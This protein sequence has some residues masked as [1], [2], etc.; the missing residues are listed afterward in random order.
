MRALETLLIT[1]GALLLL[2]LLLGLLGVIALEVRWIPLFELFRH[3]ARERSTLPPFCRAASRRYCSRPC[4]R[5]APADRSDRC[6]R[7][8]EA[9]QPRCL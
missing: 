1:I 5:L 7:P 6:E 4:G 3:S 9:G 2:L 8:T